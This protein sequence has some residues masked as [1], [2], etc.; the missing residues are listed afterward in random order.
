MSKSK[1]DF[2]NSW[3]NCTDLEAQHHKWDEQNC[4]WE[5]TQEKLLRLHEEIMA[6]AKKH[7]RSIGALGAQ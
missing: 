4:K 2:A 3:Q 5:A 1:T 6:Q 7:D